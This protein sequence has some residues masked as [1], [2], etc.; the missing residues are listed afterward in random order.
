[1]NTG[2][3]DFIGDIHGYADELEL[4]LHKLGYSSRGGAWK[5]PGRIAFFVGDFIDR[6]P[7]NV[8]AVH[9]VRSMIELNI[10]CKW[11]RADEQAGLNKLCFA[12]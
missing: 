8:E 12:E 3:I 7:K 5:H 6:G 9:L 10:H 2:G 11:H 1:M 4:L